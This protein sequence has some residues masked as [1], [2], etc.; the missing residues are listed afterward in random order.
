MAKGMTVGGIDKLNTVINQLFDLQHSGL[1]HSEKSNDHYQF[2]IK[3][4]IST[5]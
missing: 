4:I 1:I 2:K 3:G 5:E